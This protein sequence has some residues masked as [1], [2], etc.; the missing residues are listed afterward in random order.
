VDLVESSIGGARDDEQIVLSVI[1]DRSPAGGWRLRHATCLVVPP[2]C[3]AMS[4]S[5][6]YARESGEGEPTIVNGPL[7][8]VARASGDNWLVARE[9][10]EFSSAR[11]WLG[12]VV[13]LAEGPGDG[14]LPGTGKVPG[15][16]ASFSEATAVIRAMP[17]GDSP[18]GSLLAGAARPAQ[19]VLWRAAHQ[20]APV[21]L[22]PS[23]DVERTSTTWPA[24]DLS[25]IHLTP[26]YVE[27]RL[28][29]PEGVFAGRLERRAW[30]IGLRGTKEADHKR[31]SIGWEPAW[32]DPGGLVVQTEEFD[33]TGEML[34]S[35]QIALADLDLSSVRTT[36][37]CQVSVPSLGTGLRHAL[38]LYAPDGRLLDR[39]A[40]APF[41]ES[42][43]L[44]VAVD[45]SAPTTTTIASG[46]SPPTMA[47]RQALQEDLQGSLEA[48]R[49]AGA[50][51]RVLRDRASG[52]ARL[53]A[54]LE[55]ARGELLVSDPY[56]GQLAE[57]WDLV[58]GLEVPT[59][60]L[61]RR[62]GSEPAPIPNG[63]DAR[64][65]PRASDVMHDRVYVWE[66]GGFLLGGSP[67]T[68]GG[69][70][71]TI[72]PLSAMDAEV[73]RTIFEGVWSSPHFRD[74]ER[75]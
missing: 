65:R 4:W 41:V 2:E 43:T 16:E 29:T 50:E 5:A 35:E 36:G 15:L 1:A 23:V 55:V 27:P 51:N 21:D 39:T 40:P 3:A 25:G 9:Q 32:I 12:Q 17:R 61:T 26:E 42:I 24:R 7:P 18:A 8:A 33:A 11:E 53:R 64:V 60:V 58:K 69:P 70:P 73:Q 28:R 38:S 72:Q 31:V 75:R 62:I 13:A 48:L 14:P 66:G 45:D 22:P 44:S 56:F 6:W 47:E 37:R 19:G 74:V 54:L 49:R 59:R 34:L 46:V 63:V 71:V 67:S 10:L 20:P 68:I 52:L 57:D 30:L